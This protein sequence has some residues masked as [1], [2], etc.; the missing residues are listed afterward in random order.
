MFKSHAETV[1]TRVEVGTVEVEGRTFAAHGAI[2]DHDAGYLAGYPAVEGG[3]Y[4]LKSWGGETIAPLVLVSRWRNPRGVFSS[5]T[6][7]WRAT[8]GGKTYHGRNG[9]TGLLLH[10]R[11]GR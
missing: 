11:A 5:E 9:G 3:A 10:M 7:A 8:L 2:V 1:T 6:V 4:V